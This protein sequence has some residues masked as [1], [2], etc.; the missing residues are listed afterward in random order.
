[1]LMILSVALIAS[2]ASAT[3]RTTEAATEAG[4]FAEAGS[5][6]SVTLQVDPFP[7]RSM[8]EAT[9]AITVTDPSGAPLQGAIV[10]CDM[11]MPAMPMP[12]NR[13]EA[14]E[15]DPGVYLAKVLFTM[16]GDWEAA[17]HVALPDGRAE[18]FTFAMSTG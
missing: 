2:C 12:V 16:A 8:R 18:T 11:T 3:E 10:T 15:G 4:H 17:V 5:Q 13:P 9:F 14:V 1:M 7:P 6:M